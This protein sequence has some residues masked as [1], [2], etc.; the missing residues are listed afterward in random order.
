M[1]NLPI[2]PEQRLRVVNI[3]DKDCVWPW[4]I[5]NGEVLSGANKDVTGIVPYN[6]TIYCPEKNFN[7]QLRLRDWLAEKSVAINP[8]VGMPRDCFEAYKNSELTEVGD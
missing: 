2:T 8:C 5:E 3:V 6:P 4:R 1:T 7:Q